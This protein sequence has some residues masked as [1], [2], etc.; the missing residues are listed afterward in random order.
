MY[1]VIRSILT[2]I[3]KLQMKACK[4]VCKNKT[5]INIKS[6]FC[7]SFSMK[8]KCLL[9]RVGGRPLRGKQIEA[10]QREEGPV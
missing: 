10:S 3:Y 8:S 4:N 9:S 7:S 1:T 2:L 6:S 5:G